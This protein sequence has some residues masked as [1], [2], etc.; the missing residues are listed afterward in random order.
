MAPLI[1]F[2]QT[3]TRNSTTAES[4]DKVVTIPQSVAEKIIKDLV[5]ADSI[6]AAY[7]KLKQQARRDSVIVIKDTTLLVKYKELCSKELMNKDISL[8]KFGVANDRLEDK[9]KKYKT[10][11]TILSFVTI[12]AIGV[13]TALLV[14]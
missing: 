6:R 5:A 10:R 14:R 11:N 1:L 7:N 12:V 8:Y 3:D 2:S 9:V 4:K 13:T